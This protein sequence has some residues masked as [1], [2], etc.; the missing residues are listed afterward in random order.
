MSEIEEKQEMGVCC[1][2]DQ[3]LWKTRLI[4][5]LNILWRDKQINQ[6][7]TIDP[8]DTDSWNSEDW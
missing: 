1:I 5:A 7:N 2:R 4:V 8:S 6:K 3:D